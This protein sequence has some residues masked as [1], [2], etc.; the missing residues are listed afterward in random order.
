MRDDPIDLES[1]YGERSI[2]TYLEHGG[3]W[4]MASYDLGMCTVEP[5]EGH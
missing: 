1:Q 3:E 4:S 2:T 5:R